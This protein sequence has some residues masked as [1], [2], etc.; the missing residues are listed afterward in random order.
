M[1]IVTIRNARLAFPDLFEPVQFQ[2]SGPFNWR[3]TFLIDPENPAKA[4][5]E[6]AFKQVA[7]EKWGAKA[8]QFLPSILSAPNK[9]CLSDGNLKAYNGFAGN[10]AVTATRAQDFTKKNANAPEIVDRNRSILTGI[11]GKIYAG[12]FV[13]G[14][15][16]V[17]AQDNS[18]GKGL[19]ATLINVQYV[20]N[21][22]SFGGS[23][24]ATSLNLEDLSFED[25][26]EGDIDSI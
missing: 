3:C 4:A 23:A 19:R 25:D 7:A 6:A 5:I 8:Q 10:W 12:A 11:E 22:D 2:G 20:K 9:C 13:N 26:D 16:D 17:W 14:T 21:G 24:P 18:Y 15:V 1:A